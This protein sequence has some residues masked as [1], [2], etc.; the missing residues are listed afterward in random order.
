MFSYNKLQLNP[1][2]KNTVIYCLKNGN[3][4]I[5]CLKYDNI[6]KHGNTIKCDNIM[7]YDYNYIVSNTIILSNTVILSNVIILSNKTIYCLKCIIH[8]NFPAHLKKSTVWAV[9]F[10]CNLPNKQTFSFLFED[11]SSVLSVSFADHFL[12]R[13]LGSCCTGLMNALKER[14]E[15][16]WPKK[17]SHWRN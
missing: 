4:T 9:D 5:Y 12:L 17:L 6:I 8:W 11:N 2:A 14:M 16:F 13:P 1:Y 15:S 3:T 10:P 7:K